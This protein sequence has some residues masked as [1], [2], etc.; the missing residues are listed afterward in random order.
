M[1]TPTTFSVV[2]PHGIEEVFEW[3]AR[4]GAFGRLVPP[5][6]PVR[7]IQEASNLRDGV[8]VL[9]MPAGGR[10]VATHRPS[11]FQ[12][13]HRFVDVLTSK[14]YLLPLSWRH[15]HL[16]EEVRVDPGLDATRVV[17]VV[18][19]TVPN[20]MLRSMF[21]Y[22]QRQLS[23]DLTTWSWARALRPAP[24]TVAVTGASGLVGSALIPLLTT[25]GFRVIRLVRGPASGP[26]ERTWD[27]NAPT[28]ELLAGVD[29]VVHLAGASIAGR[30]NDRHKAAVRESRIEPTRLLAR[31][32]E[33]A[34]V[35]VF[36]SASAIGL[37][38][39]DRGDEVLTEA[40]ERGEGFLADVV[41]DWEAAA[42]S[43]SGLRVVMVRTGIVQSPKGGALKL[44]LP[45]FRAGVGGR[46]GSGGQWTAWIGIDDLLDV[47]LRALVD[48]RL[49]GPVNA[50]APNPVT[51]ADWTKALGRAVHRPS[52]V[53]VPSFGPRLLLG[54]EGAEEVALAGQ[55]V[56]P[57]ALAQVGHRFRHPEVEPALRHLL[58]TA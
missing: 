38:G 33:A 30:F 54:S 7:L 5:W 4:P 1:T 39:P 23:D 3:H 56:L 27:P 42:A 18:T 44:Q 6:Q 35:E 40:S 2:V 21:G 17:D 36:V 34:G 22:R 45:L 14:P 11:E 9:G 31:A 25:G 19:T 10:W 49:S 16:F 37:Y 52:V 12:A 29:A 58:G 28:P 13:P 32:A 50:V 51:N 24:M 15:E 48:D 55:R 57:S 53:P 26:T 46:L 8:A 47:Y 20:R 43:V 41:A